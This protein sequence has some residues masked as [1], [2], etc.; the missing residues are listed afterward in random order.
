MACSRNL[1]DALSQILKFMFK[2]SYIFNPVWGPISPKLKTKPFWIDALCINEADKDEK[3]K[4]VPRMGTINE[5]AEEVFGWV[6]TFGPEEP[7]DRNSSPSNPDLQSAE[8]GSTAASRQMGYL[9]ALDP[10]MVS[11]EVCADVLF[12]QAK[13]LDSVHQSKTLGTPRIANTLDPELV[14]PLFSGSNFDLSCMKRALF[15][16]VYNPW[17]SRIV[18]EAVLSRNSPIV[19]SGDHYASLWSLVSVQAHIQGRIG[20]R[21]PQGEGSWRII[22]PTAFFTEVRNSRQKGIRLH[23][24]TSTASQRV[25]IEIHN[26]FHI[27]QGVY[28]ATVPH[29][30]IYG[31]LGL[32]CG[33][34]F[35]DL[36][37]TNASISG[38]GNALIVQGIELA[39][40]IACVGVFRE[41]QVLHRTLEEVIVRNVY[42]VPG[43]S[44]S[45]ER[46]E[47]S[48]A[49]IAKS[50][51]R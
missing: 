40:C 46:S 50:N 22:R 49:P 31:L 32:D 14:H 5:S 9:S 11:L 43:G 21:T 19:I 42:G 25:A 8:D 16:L 20:L 7:A 30:Q 37:R 47:D 36:L 26:L 12:V 4:Q 3:S 28:R 18:Q 41:I 34:R 6:G 33:R 10:S 45:F 1:H 27:F 15:A 2:R 23:G 51:K 29:D 38:D 17:F 44:G 35:G 13:V 48:V 39:T 24:P